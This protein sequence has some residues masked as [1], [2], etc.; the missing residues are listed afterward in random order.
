MLQYFFSITI[1]FTICPLI[2]SF[3][4]INLANNETFGIIA[5]SSSLYNGENDNDNSSVLMFNSI[6]I[7]KNLQS[8]DEMIKSN[9]KND[10][11]L[12]RKRQMFIELSEVI[13]GNRSL[14]SSSP[15]IKQWFHQRCLQKCVWIFHYDVNQF[16]RLISMLSW[17]IKNTNNS[18]ISGEPIS[19]YSIDNL[20]LKLR[21]HYLVIRKTERQ[22][23]QQCDEQF[24]GV[25][26]F[27]MPDYCVKFFH[28]IW[29]HSPYILFAITLLI[30]IIL[31]CINCSCGDSC[32]CVDIE[33]VNYFAG[34]KVSFNYNDD[35]DDQKKP[36]D[37]NQQQQQ[38][39]IQKFVT[40]IQSTFD[41]EWK[42]VNFSQ[43][44]RT[45][46]QHTS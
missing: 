19:P 23:F 39:T 9:E 38:Q 37:H 21:Y 7:R 33:R 32:S 30:L 35:N 12:C 41:D 46:Q 10:D 34:E 20:P 44:K 42:K 45:K 2:Y 15:L 25:T 29:L 5:N 1:L 17:I 16:I 28:F 24:L 18:Y 3:P 43:E 11:E 27:S 40:F 31:A 14:S 4:S 6:L 26:L 22:C 8:N 36:Y 13:A